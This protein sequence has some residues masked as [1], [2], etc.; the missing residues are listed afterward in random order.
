MHRSLNEHG[1]ASSKRIQQP[2]VADRDVFHSEEVQRDVRGESPRIAVHAVSEV[3][4]TRRPGCALR[5]KVEFDRM[6]RP[7]IPLAQ[8]MEAFR[9]VRFHCVGCPFASSGQG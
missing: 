5:P 6:P 4:I 7:L 9:E 2:A 3:V 1:P 8:P